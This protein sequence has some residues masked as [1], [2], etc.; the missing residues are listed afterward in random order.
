M[1]FGPAWKH[2]TAAGAVAVGM[3]VPLGAFPQVVFDVT[4]RIKDK[5]TQATT[6]QTAS[7]AVRE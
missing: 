2:L 7:F 1:R 3:S 5:R 4:V 6:T